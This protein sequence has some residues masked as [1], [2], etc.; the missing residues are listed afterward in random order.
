MDP[1]VTVEGCGNF[2]NE[3]TVASILVTASLGLA[4]SL[5]V[6]L[7]RFTQTASSP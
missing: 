2:G 3:D 1:G 7:A 5:A 6:L 4:Y